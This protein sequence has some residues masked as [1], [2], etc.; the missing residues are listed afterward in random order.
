MGKT[1]VLE[2]TNENDQRQLNWL[3][4]LIH[5][6]AFLSFL[7]IG[8]DT[9]GFNLFGVNIRYSQ[10]ILVL[11]TGLL[12][13]KAKFNLLSIFRDKHKDVK[14]WLVVAFVVCGLLSSLISAYTSRAILF[15]CFIV[16]NVIFLLLAMN[17]YMRLYPNWALKLF[18]ISCFTVFGLL[19]VQI[20]CWFL[21]HF[22]IPYMFNKQYHNGIYRFSL[23]AYEPSYFATYL[24]LWLGFASVKLFLGGEKKY[25]YDIVCATFAILITT[26]TSGMIGIAL[27]FSIVFF[28]WLFD[29]FKWQKLLL[30]LV[31][32]VFILLMQFALTN[33]WET[34]VLRLFN[35]SLDDATGGRVSGWKYAFDIFKQ[36]PFFGVGPGC[37]G[38]YHGDVEEVPSNV[39]LELLSTLGIFATLIFIAYHVVLLIQAL[40]VY[41]RVDNK[42]D[43]ITL[44]SLVVALTIFVIVLQVNQ[45]YLRLYHWLFLGFL[46]GKI[47]Y[48]HAALKSNVTE[49][50]YEK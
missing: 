22:E 24:V 31:P 33:V 28:L 13:I 44:L 32:V 7:L 17:L 43:A 36:F 9:L 37:F 48:Y 39:T 11:L 27:I 5:G 20:L 45:G 40:K 3:D 47:N 10:F 16:Y 12:L 21:F 49:V 26:S 8:A 4:Y 42:Q 15:F 1:P 6:C 18:R 35:T 41:T 14:F 23:W 30:L 25:I 19:I 34:F 50:K 46:S 2:K 38:L 29:G